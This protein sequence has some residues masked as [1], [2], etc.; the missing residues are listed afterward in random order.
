M[1]KY[2]KD[3]YERQYLDCVTVL[4]NANILIQL[5]KSED[6]GVIGWD[7]KEYPIPS[8]EQVVNLIDYNRE[9]VEKKILQ[10]FDHLQLTPIAMSIPVLI[11]RLKTAIN[12]SISQGAIYQT[13]HNSLEP[14]IPVLV[15]AEKQVWIWE[16][17]K[18]R[19]DTNELVYFPQ[20]FSS[21]HK[22]LTK[23]QVI[24][25]RNI[26]ALPGWSVCLVEKLPIIPQQ[27]QGIIF[28][29]RKQLEIGFSPREYLQILQMQAYQGETGKT[30]EDF[31]ISFLTHLETTNEVS[32]D[33][34]DNNALWLIGQYVK[35]VKTVK[36]DLVP[37]GWWHRNYG[38]LRLDAHRPGNKQC[39][40]NWGT[41]TVVRLLKRT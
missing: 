34:Y 26:C 25:H 18:L 10:G 41:S 13:R 5:S 2:P 1:S 15:N 4:K 29:R 16:T 19:L 35:Y 32:N 27:G 36:S 11:E 28:E 33:R 7:G 12:K 8:Y 24:N 17:L 30:L 31:I 21:N 23:L 3:T 6:Y 39:T 20:E 22:G 14:L 9:L 37:T 38:R 40:K